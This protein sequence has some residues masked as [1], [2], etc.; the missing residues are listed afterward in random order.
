MKE[1][2]LYE[3]SEP[4]KRI[5]VKPCK[6][7]NLGASMSIT[8][9]L[10][11][12][13]LFISIASLGS[14]RAA[15]ISLPETGGMRLPLKGILI[16]G[17]IVKGDFE[18]FERLVSSLSDPDT[19]WLAS[20]GGDL[21]E[22]IK[23]GQLIRKMKLAVWAPESNRK[24]WLF[25]I[26]VND[27]RNN[28]CAGACFFIYASGV[29][30]YGDV[31]GIHRPHL[32]EEDLRGMSAEQAAFDQLSANEV[33][34][35]YL[36]KMGIPDSIIEKMNSIEQNDIQW[37]EEDEVKSLSGAIS[38]YQAWLDAECSNGIS[39]FDSSSATQ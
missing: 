23:I 14:V 10:T 33:A 27:S 20:P 21:A 19:V 26:H 22:A 3:H 12:F 1:S 17:P 32:T 13:I 25:M 15:E 37:L 31:L 36:R 6:N 30:R 35:A 39:I 7:H 18:R 16:E 4:L 28:L 8:R 24:L 34:S 5:S 11:A 29:D 9:I 2:T 38:E